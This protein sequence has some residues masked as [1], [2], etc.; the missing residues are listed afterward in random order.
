MNDDTVPAWLPELVF[1][2]S[3]RGNWPLYLDAI[4]RFFH[5]DFVQSRPFYRGIPLGLKRHPMWKDKEATFWHIIQEGSVETDRTPDLRRCER[6]RWPRPIIKNSEETAIKVWENERK[7]ETRIC[8]WFED[9]EYLVVL[10]RRKNTLLPWTAYPTPEEHRKRK[11]R[12]E[13]EAYKRLMPPR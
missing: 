7:G 1:F 11:L 3:Y 12:A 6:I 9:Q 4:Y 10:A 5:Q 2:N 13:W 8:L